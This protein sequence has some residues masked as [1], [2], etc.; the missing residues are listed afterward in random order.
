MVAERLLISSA[1]KQ[2]SKEEK[3]Q[4]SDGMCWDTREG[5]ADFWEGKANQDGKGQG[6]YGKFKK[7]ERKKETDTSATG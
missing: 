2:I 1:K 5:A 4:R 7:Q 6:D 3:P